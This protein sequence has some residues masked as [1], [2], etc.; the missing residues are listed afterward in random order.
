MFEYRLPWAL[1]GV[2]LAAKELGAPGD[3]QQFL[4]SLPSFVRFG[5]TT[6]AGVEIS[7]LVRGERSTALTLTKQFEESGTEID[8]LHNWVFGTT[9]SQLRGWFPNETEHNLE[10]LRDELHGHSAR[11][12]TLRKRGR[13]RTKLIDLDQ[14]AWNELN[15][16]FDDGERP[17]TSLQVDRQMEDDPH[18]LSVLANIDGEEIIIGFLKKQYEE[19]ILELLDWGRKISAKITRRRGEIVEPPTVTLALT[20]AITIV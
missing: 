5:V 12:W 17:I 18:V 20:S 4:D 3:L 13:I 8:D 15:R 11:N 1:S 19:E 9:L 2:A 10:R 7:K 6:T 14:D 16:R